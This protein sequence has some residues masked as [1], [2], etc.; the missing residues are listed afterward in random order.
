MKHITILILLLCF[1]GKAQAVPSATELVDACRASLEQG[2][3]GTQGMMCVW[4]VTPCNC[5][6]GKD[7]NI[8]RVC[9]PD[10]LET[11]TLAKEVLS[12]LNSKPSLLN[13]SAEMAAARIL[14][15]KYPCD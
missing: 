12:G 15:E 14:S 8:P 3:S 10:G 13:E 5:H 2:F 4:Y 11:E 6:Y 7:S 1:C 9:L